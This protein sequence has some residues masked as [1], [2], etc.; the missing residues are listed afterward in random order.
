MSMLPEIPAGSGPSDIS[1]GPRVPGYR[2]GRLLGGGGMSAVFLA[3]EES[4]GREVAVKVPHHRPGASERLHAEGETLAELDHPGI[5]RLLDQPTTED[6]RPCLVLE[7][8]PRGS[9]EDKQLADDPN[10]AA[11]VALVLEVADA[12]AHAHARGFIHRDIKPSNILRAADDTLRL[13]DF[14]C[15]KAAD[16]NTTTQII[17]TPEYMSPEQARGGLSGEIRF[18]SDVYSLGVLLFQLL[19]GKYPIDVGEAN[20]AAVHHVLPMGLQQ[21][22]PNLSDDLAR[23]CRQCLMKDPAR[24]YKNGGKLAAALRKWLKSQAPAPVTAPTPSQSPRTARRVF[25]WALVVAFVAAL[26]F[27]GWRAHQFALETQT[28]DREAA[29]DRFR[30]LIRLG[31]A[32]RDSD[33]LDEADQH[34]RGAEST[35][36][37]IDQPWRKW[38]AQER[39]ASVL[40][41]RDRLNEA[42]DAYKEVLYRAELLAAEKHEPE[43]R[44]ALAEAYCGFGDIHR[45]RNNL[46]EAASHYRTSLEK[47]TTLAARHP[48]NPSYAK[49]RQHVESRLAASK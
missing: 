30:E 19:T 12:V 32:A 9:L 4:S 40:V 45:K 38:V 33:R 29:E 22:R 31:D 46:P 6:G 37:A 24:R 14:G 16:S 11:A 5:I 36:A 39:L 8:C 48:D 41:L 26:G 1:F 7:Y 47:Y 10:G 20:R 27:G 17:G 35:V 15:V 25:V 2:L 18:P 21:L 42:E 3:W 13:S 43:A 28:R 34:Y 44:V 49:R 23:I